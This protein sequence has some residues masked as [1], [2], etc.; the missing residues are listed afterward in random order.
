MSP[1]NPGSSAFPRHQERGVLIYPSLGT[2]SLHCTLEKAQLLSGLRGHVHPDCIV[3]P[4]IH[5]L[6]HD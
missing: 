3:Q 2:Y 4:G 6:A 5:V 1:I